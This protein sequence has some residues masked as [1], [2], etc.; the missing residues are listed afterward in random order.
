MLKCR[1]LVNEADHLLDDDLNWRGRLAVRFHL[2]ICHHCR[3][4]VRQ[5]RLLLAAIPSMHKAATEQ[6]VAAVMSQLP[7]EQAQAGQTGNNRSEKP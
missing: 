3:Q 4:Y 5:L 1:E 2:L 7:A 6:E